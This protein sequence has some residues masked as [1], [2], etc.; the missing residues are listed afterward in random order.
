M[1]L[2][3]IPGEEV[4]RLWRLFNRNANQEFLTEMK[5]LYFQYYDER[6]DCT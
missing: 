2:N 1:D 5:A 6:N 3:C 4:P